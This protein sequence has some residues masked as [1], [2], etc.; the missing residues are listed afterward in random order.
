M[1]QPSKLKE[2]NDEVLQQQEGSSPA[3]RLSGTVH[4]RDPH[5]PAGVDGSVA[6]VG[7]Y[8]GGRTPSWGCRSYS[9]HCNDR[10]GLLILTGHR[11]D[12]R[13]LMVA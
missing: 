3:D 9:W 10:S 1:E 13:G 12:S 6:V 7:Q 4:V 2:N 11:E 5:R 8:G